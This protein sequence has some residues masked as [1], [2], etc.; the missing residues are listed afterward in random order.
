MSSCVVIAP[1]RY[2]N[3][4]KVFREGVVAVGALSAND[5]PWRAHEMEG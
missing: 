4:A 5:I 2:R 3:A 1:G